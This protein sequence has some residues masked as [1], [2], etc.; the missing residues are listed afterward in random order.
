MELFKASKSGKWDLKTKQR[1]DNVT[2]PDELD[3]M[4]ILNQGTV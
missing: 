1:E 4:D 2:N 3:E